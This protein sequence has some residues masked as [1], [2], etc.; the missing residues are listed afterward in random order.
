MQGSSSLE[1]LM[2]VKEVV[3]GAKQWTAK[4]RVQN[5]GYV[6]WIDAVVWAPNTHVARQALKAQFRIEDWHIGAIKELR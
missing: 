3:K 2:K 6:G 1:L 4:V 5:P